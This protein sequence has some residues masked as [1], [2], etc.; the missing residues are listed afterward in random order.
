MAD[1]QSNEHPRKQGKARRK[2]K[3]TRID[4]TAMVDV[5]FLLADF[6]CADSNTK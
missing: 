5:A 4:M 6:F 3:S 1:I 2:K